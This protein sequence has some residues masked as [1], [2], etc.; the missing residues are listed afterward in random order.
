MG[1][2]PASFS[3]LSSFW[4]SWQ[5]VGNIQFANEWIRTADP[6]CWKRPLYQLSH[7]HCPNM[8]LFFLILNL[9][10]VGRFDVYSIRSLYLF[11]FVIFFKKNGPFQALFFFYF[12]LFNTVDSKQMLNKFCQWLD[13]N[14]RPLVLEATALPTVPQPL[15]WYFCFVFDVKIK[16]TLYD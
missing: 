11:C 7:N 8:I 5:Y 4:C 14:R 10:I 2:S 15:F 9:L 6:W 1:H 12:R 16:L 13:S 3:L